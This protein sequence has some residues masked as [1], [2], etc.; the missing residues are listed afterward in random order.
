MKL[1][2]RLMPS[3]E[4]Q[5]SILMSARGYARS[6]ENKRRLENNPRDNCGQQSVFKQQNVRGQN[7]ARAYTARNNERNRSAAAAPNTQRAIVGN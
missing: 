1:Q 4:E 2:R 5:T 7:V 3:E 6:A